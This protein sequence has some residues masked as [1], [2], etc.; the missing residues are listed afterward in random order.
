MKLVKVSLEACFGKIQAPLNL[1]ETDQSLME[2]EF[3]K[4][5]EL[6]GYFY[7]EVLVLLANG[8]SEDPRSLEPNRQSNDPKGNE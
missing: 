6:R 7:P 1:S 8:K 4:I 5:A 2:T 3:E